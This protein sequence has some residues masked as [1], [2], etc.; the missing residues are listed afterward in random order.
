MNIKNIL[1]CIVI[2]IM[3]GIV[4]GLLLLVCGIIQGLILLGLA[5]LIMGLIVV[6]I[7]LFFA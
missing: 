1:R 4:I 6:I 5:I 3:F 2:S 7:N